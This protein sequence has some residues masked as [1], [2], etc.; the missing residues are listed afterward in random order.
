MV[1]AL[2]KMKDPRAVDALHRCL[3]EDWDYHVRLNAAYALYYLRDPRSIEPL[4]KALQDRIPEVRKAVLWILAYGFDKN[5]Y[6]HGLLEEQKKNNQ[7]IGSPDGEQRNTD[8]NS[9]LLNGEWDRM[10][11]LG[12][13]A[14]DFLI[15]TIEKGDPNLRI[16]AVIGLGYLGSE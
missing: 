10:I 13:P 8:L 1:R 12:D 16:D 7:S 9:L 6:Y 2:G 11:R 4:D 14:V 15:K 3:L 5:G